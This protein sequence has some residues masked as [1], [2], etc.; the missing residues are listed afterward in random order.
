MH[1]LLQQRAISGRSAFTSKDKTV[2]F[3]KVCNKL[4]LYAAEGR[5]TLH[6]RF[7]TH[8]LRSP[9]CLLLPWVD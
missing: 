4:I 6:L 1:A 7:K 3:F 9:L 2:S 5:S 8:I